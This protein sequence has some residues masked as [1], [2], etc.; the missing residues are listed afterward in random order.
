M[1]EEMANSIWKELNEGN[2]EDWGL[3]HR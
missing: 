2:P 3:G 1:D